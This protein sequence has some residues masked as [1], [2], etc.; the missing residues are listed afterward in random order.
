[1]TDRCHAPSLL[2]LALAVVL[3]GCDQSSLNNA[4]ENVNRYI[5]TQEQSAVGDAV[6]GSFRGATPNNNP[7]VTIPDTVDY[8]VEGFTTEKS[9]NWTVNDSDVPV[10]ERSDESYVWEKRDGEFVTLYY[11][12][13]DP[14]VN[15][16]ASGA[17]T[18]TFSVN[19]PDDDINSE[20]LEIT[21]VVPSIPEQ[22]TR[23]SSFST[24]ETAATSSGIATVL[25]GSGPFTV[26]SPR[27]S[28]FADLS[29][30][31]TQAVDP[32]LGEDSTSSVRGQLLQ[33]HAIA[34]NVSS[35]DISDGQTAQTL[36]ADQEVTFGV[37]GGTVTVDG[38]AEVVR[39]DIPVSNG[40]VHRLDGVLTPSTALVDFVSRT[41]P[42]TSTAAGDTLVVDG[43]FM[44]EGGGFIVLH[45]QDE[46]QNQGPIASIVGVSDYVEPGINNEVEVP[47]DEAISDTTTIGAMPHKDTDG[48]QTYD[49]QTSGGTQDTPYT[50]GNGSAENTLPNGVVIDFANINVTDPDS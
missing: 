37:S 38:D 35:G 4:P 29:A 30:L 31:P 27:D 26:L 49:F 14:T 16:T 45:D 19:S 24:L 2:L 40:A 13:S 7:T 42:D 34:A 5:I 18:N 12:T 11:T 15:A 10:A 48:D 23:L 20:T 43:S 28:A 36:L 6:S 22:V 46:L 33:Y 41:L 17:T 3:M 8:F 50:L 21:T 25:G 44:P 9:Y 32:E 39:P 1:M 47:L